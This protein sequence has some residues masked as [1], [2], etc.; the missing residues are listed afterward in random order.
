MESKHISLVRST[1]TALKEGDALVFCFV[2]DGDRVLFHADKSVSSPSGL[3]SPLKV[4]ELLTKK[5][6]DTPVDERAKLCAGW[7]RVRDGIAVFSIDVSK[8]AGARELLNGV[9]AL[10]GQLG[11]RDVKIADGKPPP[12]EAPAK[13]GQEV[14]PA[15]ES[16]SPAT[17]PPPDARLAQDAKSA[18]SAK[19]APGP[20]NVPEKDKPV[21][22]VARTF[23]RVAF[24]EA[25]K[26]NLSRARDSGEAH[27]FW[28]AR[29]LDAEGKGRPILRV[30]KVSLASAGKDVRGLG[31]TE[32]NA[33][34][35]KSGHPG[36]DSGAEVAAG[37]VQIQDGRLVF[38]VARSQGLIPRMLE[39][40]GKMNVVPGG[41][42]DVR[43]YQPAQGSADEAELE[44]EGAASAGADAAPAADAPKGEA[45][46]RDD[47]P[48]ID[49]RALGTQGLRHWEVAREEVGRQIEALRSALLARS[50]PGLKRVA[51]FGF[52]GIT[53]RLQVGLSTALMDLEAAAPA[54]RARALARAR[55]TID[56]LAEFI[57]KDPTIALLDD[58]PFEVNVSIRATLGKTL[59]GLQNAA[60][61]AT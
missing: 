59:K 54:D 51:E 17:K 56:E 35:Q 48:E 61:A 6:L 34:L 5:K 47:A 50:N 49:P 33:A 2:L 15:P 36:L 20:A 42:F 27:A 8:G 31:M 16:K 23:D 18:Q 28:F 53:G 43:R 7:V 14:K 25:A 32:L 40:L 46:A 52:N 12:P 1:L 45:S 21:E 44:R 29:V 13:A 57:E 30:S 37:Q 58:N 9:K 10:K 39:S 22:P 24:L 55:T 38:E 41:S 60:Q 11:L 19:P 3:G 26:T 4:N